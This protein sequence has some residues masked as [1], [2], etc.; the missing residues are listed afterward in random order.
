MHLAQHFALVDGVDISPTMIRRA[1][2]RGLPDN[3]RL[4]VCSGRDLEGFED[5]SFDFVFSHH[6][7]QHVSEDAIIESYLREIARVLRPGGVAVLQ[8]D[9]RRV[10]RLAAAL[11]LLPDPLLPRTRRRGMRRYRRP[12]AQI[13]QLGLAAGLT[14]D[15]EREPDSHRHWFRWRL[16]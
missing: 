10:S 5:H 11:H 16:P 14:L 7:F 9:T 12:A 3:V 8:H 4:C 1:V 2:E 15:A 6:V 13:R